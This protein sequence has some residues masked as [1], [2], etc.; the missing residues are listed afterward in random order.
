MTIRKFYKEDSALFWLKFIE[1]QLA[2]SNQYVLQTESKNAASFEVAVII[3]KLREIIENRQKSQYIPSEAVELFLNLEC[4]EHADA[5]KYVENFY[6]ELV[7]YLLKWSRSLDGTEVFS[8]MHLQV[9]PDWEN[10]VKPSIKFVQQRFSRDLINEDELFDQTSLLGQHVNLNLKTWNENNV[11]S[12][13]RWIE[14]FCSMNSQNRPIQQI[15][16][17]VQ[18]AFS[19]PGTST[20]V[21]RLF[22]IINDVWAPNK[23]NMQLNTLE[24]ILNVKI[25]SDLSCADYYSQIKDNKKL[26]AKVQANEKYK[27][28]DVSQPSSSSALTDH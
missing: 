17:L 8:W 1:S 9:C 19:I 6:S 25:N 7:R 24:A 18:Y 28:I 5:K 12:D 20:E 27:N 15:S 23:G 26:L 11:P 13:R 3:F 16:F 14:T 10:D 21:E 4:S 2:L 22:S